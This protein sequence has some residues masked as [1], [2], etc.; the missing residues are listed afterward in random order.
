M[1]FWKPNNRQLNSYAV[2]DFM[3]GKSK[4]RNNID[5]AVSAAVCCVEIGVTKILIN[6]IKFARMVEILNILS[7]K[8][9]IE[10]EVSIGRIRS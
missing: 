4:N 7:E 9:Y 10:R 6:K 1:R 5:S 8:I 3:D 2:T